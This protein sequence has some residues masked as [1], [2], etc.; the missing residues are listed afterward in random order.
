ME[1]TNLGCC[2]L[3]WRL[4]S[5]NLTSQRPHSRLMVRTSFEDKD[6]FGSSVDE[7]MI[8]LRLRIKEM[9]M[10]EKSEEAPSDWMELEKRFYG[11][12]DEDVFEAI[13]LL[14]SYLMSLR[15][16]VALGMLVLVALSVLITSGMG[17]FHA[18]KMAK[19][20]LYC[21]DSM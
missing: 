7:N 1:A 19:I 17:L 9:K 10:L 4:V 3:S 13:G 11:H 18:M 20:L 14:Q 5:K 21:F 8:V 15:P 16:S 6:H 12:Y 2:K